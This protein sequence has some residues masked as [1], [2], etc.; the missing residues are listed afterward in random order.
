MLK[1]DLL[2]V[3]CYAETMSAYLLILET[4]P[5]QAGKSY[6]ALPL[7]CTLVHWFWAE[8]EPQDL[9]KRL[10]RG[11]MPSPAQRFLLDEEAVFTGQ[12]KK[13]PVPV[14]VSKVVG[15]PSLAVLHAR[16]C[17]LLD[18]V[19]A[20]Y[21]APQYVKGGF[22]PHIT[23]QS[24]AKLKKGESLLSKAVYLIS[25]EAPEY[26]NPRYIVAKFKLAD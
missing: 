3:F 1:N 23:H 17:K 21:S 24:G 6:P 2:V 20:E 18:A 9:E 7:H 14:I 15:T 5:M 12:T 10:Q 11:L 16:A 22:N 25:A 8:L 13:G 26:G 19:G 4:T